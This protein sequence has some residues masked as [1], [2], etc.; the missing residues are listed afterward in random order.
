VRKDFKQ[1]TAQSQCIDL[2]YN[3]KK[4]LLNGKL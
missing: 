2:F 1:S 4:S 3:S